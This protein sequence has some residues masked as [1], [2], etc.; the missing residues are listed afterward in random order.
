M[1]D[2]SCEKTSDDGIVR[3]AVTVAYKELRH[4]QAVAGSLAVDKDLKGSVEHRYR[5]DPATNT[6]IAFA[7]LL[8]MIFLFP[9]W[10]FYSVF[11]S[12]ICVCVLCV[13]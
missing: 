6:M 9:L 5:V 13:I 1:S 3:V 12:Y 7:S 8:L 11:H 10:W 2:C 4:A